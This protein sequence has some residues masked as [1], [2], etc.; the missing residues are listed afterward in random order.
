MEVPRQG[1]ESELKLP[2]YTTATAIGDPR[3]VCDLHLSSLQ[4][5]ILNPLSKD[6]DQTHVL[7]DA[8][9]HPLVSRLALA[10]HSILNAKHE[11]IKICISH[12]T[13]P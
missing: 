2:A 11:K 5:R 10:Q 13:T 8:N 7:M 3:H 9:H 1:V 6:R 12:I 4:H